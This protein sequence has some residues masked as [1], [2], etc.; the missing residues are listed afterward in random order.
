[1]SQNIHVLGIVD[2]IGTLNKNKIRCLLAD[3]AQ[4]VSR[5]SSVDGI[6]IDARVG[7]TIHWRMK[8]LQPGYKICVSRIS[9]SVPDII[10]NLLHLEANLFQNSLAIVDGAWRGQIR[11]FGKI[12]YECHVLVISDDGGVK[13][14]YFLPITVQAPAPPNAPTSRLLELRG[15]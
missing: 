7:D 4:A 2:A 10:A 6:C 8:S 5:N 12:R 3:D 15:K 9:M 13:G 1:M 11:K 14:P